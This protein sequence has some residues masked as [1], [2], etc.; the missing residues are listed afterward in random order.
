MVDEAD[1]KILLS[2]EQPCG[3]SVAQKGPELPE[4][5]TSPSERLGGAGGLRRPDLG[6][7]ATCWWRAFGR[8]L[9]RDVLQAISSC[10]DPKHKLEVSVVDSIIDP[11]PW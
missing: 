8:N 3:T 2:I 6:V 5:S 4:P 7:G 11:R 1:E 9:A 10:L